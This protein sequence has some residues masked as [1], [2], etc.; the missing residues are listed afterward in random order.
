M[1]FWEILLLKGLKKF[2]YGSIQ[3]EFSNGYIENIKAKNPG[4]KAILKILNPNTAKEIIQG[5]SVAFAE[6]YINKDI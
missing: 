2:S 5:G 3:I 6:S 1:T 4:P